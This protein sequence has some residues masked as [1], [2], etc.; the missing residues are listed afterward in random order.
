[1]R[2]NCCEW[3]ALIQRRSA[4]IG[5]MFNASCV[6]K[7]MLGVLSDPERGAEI[8]PSGHASRRVA[9]WRTRS[10]ISRLEFVRVPSG[11][12]SESIA[13]MMLDG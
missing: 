6:R 13:S 11:L 7:E 1:M 5:L 10:A 9:L 4:T 2:K 8:Y 3:S 12:L